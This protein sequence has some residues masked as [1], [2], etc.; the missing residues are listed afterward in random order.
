MTLSGSGVAANPTGALNSISGANSYAGAITLAGNSTIGSSSS[1]AGDGLTLSGAINTTASNFGLTFTGAGNTAAK[2]TISGGGAVTMNG[3]GT[4]SLS[5]AN[6]YT[7]STVIQNGVVSIS[8]SNSAL[9][10]GGVTLAGGTLQ[11]QSLNANT[12]GVN[13]AA[14]AGTA[15]ST[16]G[17]QP[18]TLGSTVTAGVVPMS[19]WNDFVVTRFTNGG[20]KSNTNLPLPQS[21]PTTPTPFTLKNNA[22]TVTTA[23]VTAWQ[24]NNTFSVY[25]A[26]QTNPNAQLVNGFIGSILSTGGG[27]PTF[28]ATI[29]I[30]NV[31]VS[32]YQVYVYFN[33]NNVGQNAEIVLNSGSYT[34]PTYFVQTQGTAP[35]NGANYTFTSGTASTAP[36]TYTPSNYVAIPVPAVGI[37]GVTNAFTI[38]LSSATSG[39]SYSRHR[40]HRNR[41][42]RRPNN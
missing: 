4:L 17:E 10:T 5:A 24:A 30:G 19:N 35:L 21:V 39:A 6:S 2:G 15:G 22:G 36:G 25:G 20:D 8:N 28:P 1:V 11:F 33:N 23:Q 16:A 31:P 26:V 18:E 27:S 13:I 9:G 14:D 40:R 41:S 32:D 42:V 7:G 37:N 38:T 12:I 3:L 29:T 34:S